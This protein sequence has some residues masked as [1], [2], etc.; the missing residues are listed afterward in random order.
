MGACCSN[1]CIAISKRSQFGLLIPPSKSGCLTRLTIFLLNVIIS[2]VVLVA[3]YIASYLIP[4]IWGTI[5]HLFLCCCRCCVQLFRHTDKDFPPNEVSLGPIKTDSSD[6]IWL[7]MDDVNT[8]SMEPNKHMQLFSTGVENDD[9]QRGICLS[10]C[11]QCFMRTKQMTF[12]TIKAEDISQG[13]LGDCWL[14]SSLAALANQPHYIRKMFLTHQYNPRGKYRIRIYCPI[15]KKDIVIEVD[16]YIPCHKSSKKPV[17][18]S[19]HGHESWVMLLE[20]MFAKYQRSYANIEGNTMLYAM[21]VLTGCNGNH[22]SRTPQGWQAFDLVVKPPSSGNSKD[23][24]EVY[25]ASYSD[26]KKSDNDLFYLLSHLISKKCIVAAGTKG[27]DKTIEEGRGK[28]GGIVPGHAYTILRAYQPMFTTER[29]R[30]VKLRNPW[31]TFEWKGAWS[32]DSPE[33]KK[34]PQVKYELWPNIKDN[35][36][37]FWMLWEDFIDYYDS[38]DVIYSGGDG[39]DSLTIDIKEDFGILGPCC[40][41]VCGTIKYC[42]CCYGPYKL[43]CAPQERKGRNLEDIETNEMKKVAPAAA[44]S[45]F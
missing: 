26:D 5:S 41:F 3:K 36:G 11:H 28:E 39:L 19:P 38:I 18:T 16:D 7:R 20:K 25:L 35:D 34:H 22:F 43:C 10:I 14:L 24:D 21:I 1:I 15:Q 6:V 9:K 42:V 32:D 37:C 2:P 40:G 23:R 29:L 44:V 30:L 45:G 12:K 33:W 17:F 8:G 4:C 31:G 27:E 13:A